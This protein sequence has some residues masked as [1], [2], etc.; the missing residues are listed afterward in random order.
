MKSKNNRTLKGENSKLYAMVA[1][2]ECGKSDF[3]WLNQHQVTRGVLISTQC[4]AGACTIFNIVSERKI[5]RKYKRMVT[6]L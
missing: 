3:V 1:K 5:D 6:S 4:Y 2:K